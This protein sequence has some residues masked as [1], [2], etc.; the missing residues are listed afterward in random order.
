MSEGFVDEVPRDDFFEFV[1][2]IGEGDES[3]EEKIEMIKD[4]SY[5][6]WHVT[7]KV[8]PFSSVLHRGDSVR[9]LHVTSYKYICP[10]DKI[11]KE[12]PTQFISYK[13][14]DDLW[15]EFARCYLE[16]NRRSTLTDK[17]RL[18]NGIRC[19]EFGKLHR[20]RLRNAAKT[21]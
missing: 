6:W 15:E 19:I 5:E 18:R 20:E 16:L 7:F 14:R 10:Y 9:G 13:L 17:H 8:G 1:I 12:C 11:P 4:A 2:A 21:N 3:E